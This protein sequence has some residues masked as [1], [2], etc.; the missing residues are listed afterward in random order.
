MKDV[1]SRQAP[2][3]RCLG[4][5]LASNPECIS[6]RCGLRGWISQGRDLQ[7]GRHLAVNRVGDRP[8]SRPR[9][10]RADLHVRDVH[11]GQAVGLEDRGHS[12]QRMEA[13]ARQNLQLAAD[14]GERVH[15][16]AAVRAA[17]AS[18]SDLVER[19][20]RRASRTNVRIPGEYTSECGEPRAAG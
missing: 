14:L 11:E 4:D 6:D 20:R 7:N 17:A 3:L 1:V 9:F 15:H 13:T 18:L 8:C 5:E 19:P 2:C 16:H 10:H 12:A